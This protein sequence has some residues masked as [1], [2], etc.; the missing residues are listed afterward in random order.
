[1]V[2][3]GEWGPGDDKRLL[4]AL[5]AGDAQ[6]EWEVEWGEVVEGRSAQ[7]CL[8]RW[9]L[10]LKCVPNYRQMEMAELVDYMVDHYCPRLRQEQQREQEEE[11]GEEEAGGE[12]GGEEE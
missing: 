2:D 10:M 7:Q 12:A 8:R 3:R 1:M 5:L 9:R 4:R 11:E 6:Y